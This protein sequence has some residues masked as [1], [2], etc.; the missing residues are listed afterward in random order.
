MLRLFDILFVNPKD[1]LV[2]LHALRVTK[3]FLNIYDISSG[4]VKVGRANGRSRGGVG[5]VRV[6]LVQGTEE[7]GVGWVGIGRV[8]GTEGGKW[9]VLVGRGV[10]EK[11]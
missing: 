11:S 9:K 8:G 7:K 4:E 2:S 1:I 6:G 5:R 3:N 10:V